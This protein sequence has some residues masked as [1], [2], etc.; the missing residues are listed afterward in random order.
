MLNRSGNSTI[1]QRYTE[2]QII[3]ATDLSACE[4]EYALTLFLKQNLLNA[5][6]DESRGIDLYRRTSDYQ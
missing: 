2:E 3:K 4:G 1:N 6:C 5:C